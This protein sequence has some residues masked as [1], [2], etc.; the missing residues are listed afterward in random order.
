MT[1]LPQPTPR[2]R[3]G[4]HL[5]AIETLRPEVS[6]LWLR[7]LGWG[8]WVSLGV[9]A[10]LGAVSLGVYGA[11]VQTQTRINQ[12]TTRLQWLQQ[13]QT[14]LII[15]SALLRHHLSQQATAAGESELREAAIFLR[16]SPTAP[17]PT[18]VTAPPT[19]PLSRPARPLGY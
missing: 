15:G 16:P 4:L 19:P 8:Q 6:P 11:S 3:S 14:Q 10:T 17:Q 1:A 12:A 9:A 2:Q 7:A 18:E 13:R 5:V